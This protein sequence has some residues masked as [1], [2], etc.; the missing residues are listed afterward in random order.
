MKNLH[1]VLLMMILMVVLVLFLVY[2]AVKAEESL[3]KQAVEK[4]SIKFYLFSIQASLHRGRPISLFVYPQLAHIF[5]GKT[6]IKY[7]YISILTYCK[8]TFLAQPNDNQV[9]YLQNIGHKFP[10]AIQILIWISI[11][12]FCLSQSANQAMWQLQLNGLEIRF[13][14]V[15]LVNSSNAP[16]VTQLD[17]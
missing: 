6:F 4:K 7:C 16:G 5:K 14:E 1:V 13:N 15:R 8:T 11:L 10:K 3:S 9:K 2:L 12:P 17:R